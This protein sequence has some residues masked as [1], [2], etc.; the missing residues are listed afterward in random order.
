MPI[1]DMALKSTTFLLQ[2]PWRTMFK[3]KEL[4]AADMESELNQ[5]NNVC[6]EIHMVW[7][8]AS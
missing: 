4:S 3:N 2:E 1:V 5:L 6:Q 8:K 7:E